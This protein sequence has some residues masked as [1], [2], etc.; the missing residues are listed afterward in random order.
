MCNPC[1]SISLSPTWDFT[2]TLSSIKGNVPKA[3]AIVIPTS[4]KVHAAVQSILDEEPAWAKYEI[5]QFS[6]Y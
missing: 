5:P 3:T 4:A 6:R 1:Y 2:V